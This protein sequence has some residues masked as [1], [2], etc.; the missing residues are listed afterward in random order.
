MKERITYLFMQYYNNKSTRKELEE[1]FQIINRAKHD[2]EINDLIKNVYDEIKQ[3]NPSLTYINEE[4]KLVLQEPDWLYQPVADEPVV[5]IGRK[6]PV[7]SIAAGI[8]LIMSIGIGFWKFKPQPG[9][10]ELAVVK[11]FTER[12]EHKY[13]LLSDSTQ[14][15]LNASS[16]IDYPEKFN[17]EK[18][19]VYLT[20]EAYFDVKHADKVP[21]V[22]HTGDISTV[23]LGT[24]FNI[25]AY[26]G[27][28]H[29]TVS[30]K[31]GKV[32]VMQKDKVISTLIKGQ[33]VKIDRKNR[34]Y[35]MIEKTDSGSEV[36]SWQYGY[37]VY[38][39]ENFEDI[40]SDMQSV[41]NVDIRIKNDQ[42]KDLVVTTS[43][44]RNIGVE[45]ALE[46]L[47]RLTDSKLEV[48]DNQYV[49]E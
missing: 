23:V 26:T 24:A 44:N 8:I 13:L 7:W 27:Q 29:I 20:G 39:D 11:K 41:Y 37:L 10:A 45:R 5:T 30:V 18:R 6:L 42:L 49:V 22:I 28:Q 1:F 33:G 25:K 21:F 31:R 12:T 47:C 32:Q 2:D 43:F 38:E 35:K 40:I 34:Q 48:K 46:I 17:P 15:W 4:G 19:E 3:S 9:T 14:V 16:T 36:G